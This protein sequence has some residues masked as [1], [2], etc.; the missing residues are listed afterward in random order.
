[1]MQK[2]R[3]EN[4]IEQIATGVKDLTVEAKNEELKLQLKKE[5]KEKKSQEDEEEDEEE[6]DNDEDDETFQQYKMQRIR[7]IQ[8]SIPVFG[9]FKRLT[10]QEFAA[11]SKGENEFVNLVVHIYENNLEA[12]VRTNLALEKMAPQFPHV[13]FVRIRRTE[14]MPNYSTNGLPTLLVY[15]NG[16]LIHSFIRLTDLVGKAKF[17]EVDLA[18]FLASKNV[19]RL[20]GEELTSTTTSATTTTT[21]TATKEKKTNN[22]ITK[23]RQDDDD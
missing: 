8:N 21:T 10:L 13:H 17:N 12:C 16:K 9:D 2:I 19:L 18:K 4:N 22:K 6:E 1:M 23:K 5:E 15:R 14:A 20:A 7:S 3:R 11:L